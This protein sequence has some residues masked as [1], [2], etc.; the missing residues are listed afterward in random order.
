M[1]KLE[2][3]KLK[4]EIKSL[5]FGRFSDILKGLGIILDSIVLFIA[6]QMPE[7][8]LNKKLSKES[9]KYCI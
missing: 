7:S 8:I 5:K 3:D 4:E 2:E 1:T 9:I 6:I